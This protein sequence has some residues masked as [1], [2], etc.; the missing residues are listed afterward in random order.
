MY[1]GTVQK[2]YERALSIPLQK[3]EVAGQEI[4]LFRTDTLPA[5]IKTS[6]GK[7]LLAHYLD[8]KKVKG[9]TRSVVVVG[10]GNTVQGIKL[11]VDEFGLDVEVVAVVY[12]ETSQSVVQKL[13]AMDIEVVME[14][15]RRE[16]RTGRLSTAERL[17]KKNRRHVLLEQHEQP[18][19]IDIQKRTFGRAIVEKVPTPNYFVAGVGTGGTLFGIGWVL[20]KANP[21]TKITAV[22]GVGSTLSLWHAYLGAVGYEAMKRAIKKAL[23]AYKCAGMIV[24]LS[25][26]P[27]KSPENWFEINIDFPESSGVLGIEGLGVGDPTRLVLDHLSMVNRVRIITD[28]EAREGVRLLEVHGISCVESAGAN[29]LAAKEVATKLKSHG[30]GKR[31][32]ILTVITA[33]R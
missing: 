25:C 7:C 24:S 17:C 28:E 20:R 16:G 22:E 26:H 23:R 8:T 19:I 32:S 14:T 33:S 1:E 10:G 21:H 29:F 9:T 31:R 5:G 13:K 11:A 30:N 18:R 3:I 15:P 2:E 6:I 4:V 12:A 27:G